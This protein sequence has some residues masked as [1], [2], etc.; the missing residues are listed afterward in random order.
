MKLKI[1]IIFL[2]LIFLTAFAV[3]A[4][5]E[6]VRNIHNSDINDTKYIN[7][8]DYYYDEN[9]LKVH[10]TSDTGSYNNVTMSNGYNAYAIQNGGYINTNDSKTHPS[11]W[12]DTFHVV[13]ANDTET[14]VG[15]WYYAKKDPIG[16]YLKILFYTQY[17]YI[18]NIHS[19]PKIPSSIYVQSIVWD[20]YKNGGDTG[21]LFYKINRQSVEMYNE[22][23]RVNN[24]GNIQWLNETTYRII[25][26]LAFRNSNPIHKDLWGYKVQLFNKTIDNQTNATSNSNNSILLK[27]SSVDNQS[28]IMNKYNNQSEVK[29]LNI[30]SVTNKTNSIYSINQENKI[31]R[32]D[33]K[34]TGNPTNLLI[35]IICLIICILLVAYLKRNLK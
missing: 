13:D 24:T 19:N 3:S 5:N 11:F 29:T 34:E 14:V 9:G 31:L 21:K 6:T 2:T 1:T 25:D 16:E 33:S 22:G 4:E 30:S 18:M 32:I 7:P 28:K 27:N 20:L 35:I 15:H 26:F 10:Y 12:N 8:N 17:D 23:F